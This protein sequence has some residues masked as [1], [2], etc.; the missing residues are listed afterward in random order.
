M[1]L[2][3]SGCAMAEELDIFLLCGSN[4]KNNFFFRRRRTSEWITEI[5]RDDFVWIQ[6]H[7]PS[8]LTTRGTFSSSSW[9]AL[10]IPLAMMAQ[11][12]IPPN[13]FT[14]I[15]STC[16]KKTKEELSGGVF[17]FWLCF[18]NKHRWKI[19]TRIPI[20]L[21]QA[22]SDLWKVQASPLHSENLSLS[23][24]L[25]QCTAVINCLGLIWHG[26]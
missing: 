13:M 26:N 7:S 1:S 21:C 9:Q 20:P 4:I 3:T 2:L 15:A 17:M 22:D 6:Q 10:V 19:Q 11:F 24:L 5:L 12:T 14:R 25:L 18:L 16:R 8:S 23:L